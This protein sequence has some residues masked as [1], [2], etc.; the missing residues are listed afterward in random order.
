MKVLPENGTLLCI[1]CISAPG[2]AWHSAHLDFPC[3]ETSPTTSLGEDTMHSHLEQLT[4]LSSLSRDVV[5]NSKILCI[6]GSLLAKARGQNATM[7]YFGYYVLCLA[8]ILGTHHRKSLLMVAYPRTSNSKLIW[9]KNICN[10]PAKD[11]SGLSVIEW[12]HWRSQWACNR[13]AKDTYRRKS[14][15]LI[16]KV[17]G[18][19]SANDV[20]HLAS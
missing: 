10:I 2:I 17:E 9:K 5:L 8:V 3:N 19:I 12:E 1:V 11:F 18:N 20:K 4:D 7:F 16:T 13:D 15:K 6:I 14:R